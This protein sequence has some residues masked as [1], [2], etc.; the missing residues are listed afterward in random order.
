MKSLHTL[1][2][3]IAVIDAMTHWRV[4]CEN[5]NGRRRYSCTLWGDGR[6]VTASARTP[7]AAITAATAKLRKNDPRPIRPA[8]TKAM[9]QTAGHLRIIRGE[10]DND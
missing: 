5:S 1:D 7:L 10:A 3:A 2:Q 6:R 4:Q 9:S 8:P